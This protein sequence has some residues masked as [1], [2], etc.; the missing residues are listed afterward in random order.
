MNLKDF[1]KKYRDYDEDRMITELEIEEDLSKKV[2]I[3]TVEISCHGLE[4][5]LSQ[6]NV[7]ITKDIIRKVEKVVGYPVKEIYAED[8]RIVMMVQY[9]DLLREK[10]YGY[11][12][13]EL[14]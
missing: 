3:C 8:D 4:I 12:S 1:N 14:F 10:P 2:F 9:Q 13:F 7:C 5:Y 11:C 6:P